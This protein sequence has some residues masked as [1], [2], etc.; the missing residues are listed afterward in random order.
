MKAC[1]LLALHAHVRAYSKHV[2]ACTEQQTL[3]ICHKH[4]LDVFNI[5]DTPSRC[6]KVWDIRQPRTHV[7]RL[8]AHYHSIGVNGVI[9][10]VREG[11]GAGVWVSTCKCTV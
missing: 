4:C 11:E 1:L 7:H 9:G 6:I 5:N 10:C 2:F 3:M 8:D